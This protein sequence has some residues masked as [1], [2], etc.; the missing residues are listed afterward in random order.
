MHVYFVQDFSYTWIIELKKQM[1]DIIVRK[2]SGI[3]TL[4]ARLIMQE[5]LDVIWDFFTDPE[6]LSVITPPEMRF[7]ITSPVLH[8]PVFPG[9]I[10]SYK[11]NVLPGIRMNWVTEITHLIDR[12]LFVDEQR[13]GPYS[14]WHHKHLFRKHEEGIEIVDE[15]TYKL[16]FGVAFLNPILIRPQLI[17]IFRFR[18]RK[19]KE[20][21]P[22]K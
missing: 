22:D 19:L 11:I 7:K 15:V 5:E 20:L 14:F 16:P 12:Q 3:N 13:I 8:N 6:N 4:Y 18:S 10:I 2:H 17:K 1:N 9:Q 21:F